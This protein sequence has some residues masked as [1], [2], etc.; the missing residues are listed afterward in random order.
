MTQAEAQ[1]HFAKELE[2]V[3]KNYESGS[4]EFTLEDY[5]L[6]EASGYQTWRDYVLVPEVKWKE[7]HGVSPSQIGV[8]CVTV[9]NEKGQ[10]ETGVLQMA[11]DNLLHVRAW[12]KQGFNLRES[13]QHHSRQLRPEQAKDYRMQH[14]AELKK[15]DAVQKALMRGALSADTI[16]ARVEALKKRQEEQQALE[17][18][19]PETAETQAKPTEE[20]A[21]LEEEEEEDIPLDL[22]GHSGLPASSAPKKKRPRGGRGNGKGK[23]KGGGKG[24]SVSVA[25]RS[26]A[27]G[28]DSSHHG[29]A[30]ESRE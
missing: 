1:D 12:W 26:A 6:Q 29:Q 5:E 11:D 22:A 9:S 14:Q 15:T 21:A 28:F 8:E 23:P 2:L 18:L 30:R 20:E 19:H 24:K 25:Q 13:L 27:S 10:Q 4:Q 16:K 7:Q 3:R 17:A